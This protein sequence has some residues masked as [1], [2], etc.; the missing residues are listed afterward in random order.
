MIPCTE[1]SCEREFSIMKNVK[2]DHRAQ[3]SDDVLET[4]MVVGSSK[5]LLP[6]TVFPIIIERIGQSSRTM[7]KHLIY[8]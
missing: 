3:L 8:E 2:S 5:E 4:Y 6:S 7:R 1:V